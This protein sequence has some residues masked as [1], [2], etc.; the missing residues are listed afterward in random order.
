[1]DENEY[2][3]VII[4]NFSE[5]P[6]AID[7]G[8][9]TLR[10]LELPEFDNFNE[11][12]FMA[13]N[14]LFKQNC[15]LL[16]QAQSLNDENNRLKKKMKTEREV[17]LATVENHKMTINLYELGAEALGAKHVTMEAEKKA[18]DGRVAALEAAQSPDADATRP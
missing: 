9:N 6:Y 10:D 4:H 17:H 2:N 13:T 18:V 15:E 12:E 1:M 8:G 11:F 7:G 3:R 5:H 14:P 16:L